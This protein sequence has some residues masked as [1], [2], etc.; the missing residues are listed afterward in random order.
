MFNDGAGPEHSELLD[1]IRIGPSAVF[2][3]L[4]MCISSVP[5]LWFSFG[6]LSLNQPVTDVLVRAGKMKPSSVKMSSVV[7]ASPP[8][9]H[10]T[11]SRW[12]ESLVCMIVVVGRTL[13]LYK[14]WS[15]SSILFRT[16]MDRFSR[17]NQRTCF[18][19][20]LWQNTQSSI[21]GS[22]CSIITSLECDHLRLLLMKRFT[23]FF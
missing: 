3:G 16:F 12:S 1:I 22:K 8:R 15:L 13:G 9:I 21:S 6:V 11:I 17:S 23:L 7:L 2:T 14:T 10:P 5:I 4:L 19:S 18:E 20:G